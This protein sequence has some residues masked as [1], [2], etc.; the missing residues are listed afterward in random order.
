MEHRRLFIASDLSIAVV[1]RLLLSTHELDADKQKTHPNTR[2]K[3]VEPEN[4]HVTLKFLGDVPEP[5]LNRVMH[6]I[7]QIA[8][9]LFPFQLE[10][11]GVGAFPGVE[12]PRILW[13]G[14]D[15]K[16]AEVLTLLHQIIEKEF[17]ELGF[18]ANRFDYK[19]HVTLGRVKS[20]SAPNFEQLLAPYASKVFGTSTIRD[21]VLYESKLSSRGPE[22]TVLRRFTLGEV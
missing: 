5:A 14:I 22:Y 1:E 4:I 11:R 18:E 2:I 6:T 16:G 20:K 17:L 21:L 8:T 15:P 7:E 13:S 10:L 19:P 12:C 9:P 3:W